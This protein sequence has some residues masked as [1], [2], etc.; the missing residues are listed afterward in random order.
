[1]INFHP[2]PATLKLFAQGNTSPEVSLIISAHID[3]CPKC[4]KQVEEYTLAETE[5]FMAHSEPANNAAFELMMNGIMEQAPEVNSAM[6]RPVESETCIELDGRKF[7][8]PRALQRYIKKTDSWS[9]LVGK[10]WHAPVDIGLP[11]KAD[12][13]FMEQGGSVPE[14][15]HKGSELTLVINGEFQDGLSCYDTGDVMLMD[16]RHQHTPVATSEGGCLVFSI[17]DQPLHF[18]S[19]LARLLN[20]FSHLFFK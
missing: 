7:E 9:R 20:P 2:D 5:K 13:I 4:A 10:I 3:M 18:T 19:G 17:V 6:Q 1:M 12:F 16:S 14:H 15:T 8:L 11:G